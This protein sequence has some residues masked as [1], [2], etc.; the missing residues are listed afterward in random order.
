VHLAKDSGVPLKLAHN[1]S[2]DLPLARATK[3]QYVIRIELLAAHPA[4]RYGYTSPLGR[5]R[6]TIHYQP[7]WVEIDCYYF[8]DVF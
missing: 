2:L 1:L 3:E 8:E 7:R 5:Y 4:Q 6:P